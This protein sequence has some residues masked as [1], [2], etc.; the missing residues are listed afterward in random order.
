MRGTAFLSGFFFVMCFG[1]A[2]AVLLVSFGVHVP[3]L[4][5]V[6]K[7]LVRSVL[8]EGIPEQKKKVIL[9]HA[10]IIFLSIINGLLA[11]LLVIVYL[12]KLAFSD[13]KKFL[14]SIA[15]STGAIPLGIFITAGFLL[16]ARETPLYLLA[17][18]PSIFVGLFLLI[19]KRFKEH[20]GS[21]YRK[22]ARSFA[23]G[24]VLGVLC[25]GFLILSG[26]MGL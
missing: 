5:T 23:T 15:E 25:L 11:I 16:S 10:E 20:P 1:M 18:V 2:L 19:S 14:E 3:Y 17:G 13:R 6:S 8:A 26:G 12:L 21:F 22:V 4:D 7:D 24:T 9:D